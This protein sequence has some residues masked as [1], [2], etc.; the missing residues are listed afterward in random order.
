MKNK[1]FYFVLLSIFYFLVYLILFS[2]AGYFRYKERLVLKENLEK[3]I[4][5]LTKENQILEEKLFS[6]N[7]QEEKYKIV[8]FKF[9]EEEKIAEIEEKKI[10]S[11]FIPVQKQYLFLYFFFV[12]IGYVFLF[13]FVKN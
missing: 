5:S 13:V 10:N 9:P 8:L 11:S 3:E 4:N 2:D 12:F 6:E 1:F 7:H